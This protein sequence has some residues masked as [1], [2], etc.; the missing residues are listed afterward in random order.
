MLRAGMCAIQAGLSNFALKG[1][2]K[3]DPAIQA[4]P[5]PLDLRQPRQ[6]SFVDAPMPV[7]DAPV[8]YA[9]ALD[10]SMPVTYAPVDELCKKRRVRAT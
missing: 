6:M 8:T 4:N 5:N 7:T 1:I 10:A 2:E 9:P 3:A